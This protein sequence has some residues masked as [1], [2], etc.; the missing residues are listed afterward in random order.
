MSKWEAMDKFKI[1]NSYEVFVKRC[2]AAP[3]R[4]IDIYYVGSKAKNKCE[5]TFKDQDVSNNSS[6]AK[7]RSKFYTD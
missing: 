6:I 2:G 3:V 1:P 5:L 4:C 7:V